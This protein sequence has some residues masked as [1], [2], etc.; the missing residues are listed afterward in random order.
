MCFVAG[1]GGGLVE[2]A[3]RWMERVLVLPR[4]GVVRQSGTDSPCDRRHG[5]RMSSK[6][7]V[8]AHSIWLL[9]S[10]FVCVR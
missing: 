4:V 10:V 7:N 9:M 8:A 1:D 6:A 3:V 5:D 2:V